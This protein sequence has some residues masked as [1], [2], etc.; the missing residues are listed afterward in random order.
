[1]VRVFIRIRFY[2]QER[3]DFIIYFT[4]TDARKAQI[5][6]TE[7]VFLCSSFL[8]WYSAPVWQRLLVFFPVLAG[9]AADVGFEDS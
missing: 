8:A 4:R 1:M 9:G 2:W 3:T 6:I 5:I 7:R